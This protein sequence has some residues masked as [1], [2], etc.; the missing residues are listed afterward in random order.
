L[1]LTRFD[2]LVDLNGVAGL[3]GT[4][5]VDGHLEIGAMTRQRAVEHDADAAKAVPLLGLAL[6]FIGHFQI[7]NR[8]TIGGSLAHADPASELP[9]VAAA[10]DAEFVLAAK[11]AT[12]TLSASD[13][14][15]GTFMTAIDTG[16]LLTA[17]RFPVWGP[18]SGFGFAEFARRSG[19]FAVVGVAAGLQVSGGSVQR[20]AI[21]FSGMGGTPV[22]ATGAEAALVGAGTGSIDVEE[23]ARAAVG[24]TEP[25]DDVHAS[26]ANRRRIG[27]ALVERALRQAIAN[28]QGN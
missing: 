12:R 14:F 6:P 2:H 26:A 10:L 13:F 25:T 19:D 5:R 17:V 7:R 3:Q 4:Q 21:A 1:R 16:E 20:A 11:G 24:A 23:V 9:A 22:R 28:A 8:G 15:Q 27:T 18:G